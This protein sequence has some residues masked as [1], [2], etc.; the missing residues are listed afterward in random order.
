MNNIGSQLADL[1]AQA[2]QTNPDKLKKPKT[3]VWVNVGL[4]IP[5]N[6]ET[7]FVSLPFGIP[8][9]S[10]KEVEVPAPNGK[11]QK[12]R[13]LMQAKNALFAGLQA[14]AAELSPGQE[15]SLPKLTVRLSRI[16]EAEEEV[17][18]SEDNP[19][20]AAVKL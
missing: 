7:V 9:D 11:N 3:K 14:Q 12:F 15:I 6:G 13:H 18:E 8:F 10:M 1:L 19:L 17:S 16:N 2:I 4:E 20:L 5:V